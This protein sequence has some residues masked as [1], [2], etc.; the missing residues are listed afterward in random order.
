[1]MKKLLREL[2]NDK[3]FEGA[4]DWHIKILW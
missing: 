1:M 3:K 4:F 2:E